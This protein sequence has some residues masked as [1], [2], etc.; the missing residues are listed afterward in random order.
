MEEHHGLNPIPVVHFGAELDEMVKHIEAGY[1]FIGLGGLGQEVTANK[2]IEWADRMFSKVICN[3]PNK[4]PAVQIHGFAMTSFPLLLR[5][6]WWSVDSTSWMLSGAMGSLYVPHRRRG[7]WTFDSLIRT[8]KPYTISFSKESPDTKLRLKHFDT[9]RE[10]EQ[11]I[12]KDW[13]EYIGVPFGKMKGDDIVEY[14]VSNR[15]KE[16][17]HANLLYFEMLR[18]ALPEWPWAF[19]VN[20]PR[21]LFEETFDLITKKPKHEKCQCTIFYSGTSTKSAR[22]ED[23]L[24][25]VDIMMSYYYNRPNP[26]SRLKE[27][28]VCRK[29]QKKRHRRRMRHSSG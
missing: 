26:E 22:P 15:Y 19:E 24:P 14:G 10:K 4:K 3:T 7:V 2:Y 27:L 21:T 25:N 29:K 17:H 6:P 16:R 23:F 11:R 20:P 1:K 12:I 13:L 5:Y 28:M 9:S 18:N 8:N